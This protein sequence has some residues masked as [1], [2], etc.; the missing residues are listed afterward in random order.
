MNNEADRNASKASDLDDPELSALYQHTRQAEPSNE[1][2]AAILAA[3]R[4][5]VR[6]GPRPA[7]PF[8][9][10]WQIP[11]SIA[12][13]LVLAII[14]VP[15]M[16]PDP[17]FSQ[18]AREPMLQGIE[19]PNNSLAPAAKPVPDAA[20][21]TTGAPSAKHLHHDSAISGF[22]SR[23]QMDESVAEEPDPATAGGQPLSRT[24]M[25]AETDKPQPAPESWLKRIRELAER[26][27]ELAAAQELDAFRKTWPDYPI[28]PDLQRQLGL[29]VQDG[30]P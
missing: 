10:R 17:E 14:V 30:L 3:S 2:D 16:V 4:R 18:H 1:L 11:A 24:D 22:A 26:G 27:D 12:A 28:D 7:S 13:V 21:R 29:P 23:P 6:A 5:E 20:S 15:L 8:S 9:G 25:A 19:H